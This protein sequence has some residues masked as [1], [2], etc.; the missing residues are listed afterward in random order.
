VSRKLAINENLLSLRQRHKLHF[1][2]CIAYYGTPAFLPKIYE[3]FSEGEAL[4][5]KRVWET[6]QQAKSPSGA[7][8]TGQ[9]FTEVGTRFLC[10]LF[11]FLV[12][13]H[14]DTVVDVFPASIG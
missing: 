14:F 1:F 4:R 5:K 6:S 11:K 3:N 12:L 7:S 8:A 10:L 13:L 2:G 9:G